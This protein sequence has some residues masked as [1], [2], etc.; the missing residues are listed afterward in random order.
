MKDNT[1]NQGTWKVILHQC[2]HT[3]LV[4]LKSLSGADVAGRGVTS[5][6][7]P[8]GRGGGGEEKRGKEKGR[9]RER[10]DDCIKGNQTNQTK[11]TTIMTPVIHPTFFINHNGCSVYLH[12]VPQ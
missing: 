8:G 10:G 5:R 3:F 9:R 2:R 1:V 11:K 7:R 4:C 6:E 12:S